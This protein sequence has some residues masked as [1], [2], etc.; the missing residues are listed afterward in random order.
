M[1]RREKMTADG[2]ADLV[3]RCE[4]MMSELHEM[5]ARA[6]AS[7]GDDHARGLATARVVQAINGMV[8]AGAELNSKII[9]M[10]AMT[11]EAANLEAALRTRMAEKALSAGPSTELAVDEALL[12]RQISAGRASS[13]R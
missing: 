1:A 4:D 13:G 9:A 2:L 11:E 12:L 7:F 3:R 8:W 6:D 5:S 10:L